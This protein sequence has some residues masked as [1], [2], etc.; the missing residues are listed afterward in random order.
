M[1]T[2]AELERETCPFCD[3]NTGACDATREYCA[4]PGEVHCLRRTVRNLRAALAE[5]TKLR[6]A[7]R[8]AL[9]AVL[10]YREAVANWEGGCALPSDRSMWSPVDRLLALRNEVYRG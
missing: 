9:E 8:E 3:W 10:A 1:P 7:E 5:A 2:S 4:K 6:E